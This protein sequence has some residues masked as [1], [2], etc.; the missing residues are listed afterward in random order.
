MEVGVPV[1]LLQ[2]TLRH[3]TVDLQKPAYTTL[4]ASATFWKGDICT[5]GHILAGV[6]S[7]GLSPAEEYVFADALF[8]QHDYGA[9]GDILKG[10]F[11]LI[12]SSSAEHHSA[13]SPERGRIA[14]AWQTGLVHSSCSVWNQHICREIS[15]AVTIAKGI[16]KA[17][18]QAHTGSRQHVRAPSALPWG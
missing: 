4:F 12:T 8:S 14:A 18:T 7:S 10:T 9:S 11:E 2:P 6:L 5:L 15:G 17:I 1:P 16:V 13:S 3:V